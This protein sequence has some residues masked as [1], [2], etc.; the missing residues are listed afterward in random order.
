MCVCGGGGGAGRSN[1]NTDN[2]VVG[3]D[4]I[5]DMM[6]FLFDAKNA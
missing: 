5:Y 4:P 3:L 1:P 6:Q 2:L